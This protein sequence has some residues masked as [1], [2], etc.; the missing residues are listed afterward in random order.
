MGRYTPDEI[1]EALRNIHAAQHYSMVALVRTLEECGA[2]EAEL[3]DENL[4]ALAEKIEKSGHRPIAVL[5]EDLSNL[6]FGED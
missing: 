1:M 3:F 6:L 2:L 5:L 4:L